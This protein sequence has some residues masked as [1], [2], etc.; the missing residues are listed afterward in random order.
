LRGWE[1]TWSWC[2][3]LNEE[4]YEIN[5]IQRQVYDEEIYVQIQG[6]S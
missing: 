2:R 5:S 4:K 6:S 3:D 1:T